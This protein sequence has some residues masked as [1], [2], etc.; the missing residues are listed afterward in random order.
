MEGSKVEDFNLTDEQLQKLS[1]RDLEAL[2]R[3]DHAAISTYGLHVLANKPVDFQ[4]SEALKNLPASAGRY[5]KDSVK[6]LVELPAVAVDAYNYVK[7]GKPVIPK[8]KEIGG[9][10]ADDIV[11]KYGSVDQFKLSLQEDPAQVLGDISTVLAPLRAL[12]GAA[13]KAATT[14]VNVADPVAWAARGAKGLGAAGKAALP[15]AWPARMYSADT[16]IAN[17][18]VVQELLK[19]GYHP[20]KP[21]DLERLANDINTTGSGIR[22]IV[23]DN[24][25]AVTSAT[26]FHDML[27]AY[28]KVNEPNIAGAAGARGF[29]HAAGEIAKHMGYD[30]GNLT[31]EAQDLRRMLGYKDP[32]LT[33]PGTVLG[34]DGKPLDPGGLMPSLNEVDPGTDLYNLWEQK[35]GGWQSVLNRK[36]DLKDLAPGRA[37]GV[38]AA[39][40][41]ATF[42]V[43]D[44]LNSELAGTKYR[45]LAEK[46]GLEVDMQEEMVKAAK[47]LATSNS[48]LAATHTIPI[49]VGG[50]IG[51]SVGGSTGGLLGALT[52][53]GLDKF[54]SP[55]KRISAAIALEK[56]YHET[57]RDYLDLPVGTWKGP[58]ANALNISE[59]ERARLKRKQFQ[60]HY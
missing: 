40:E 22:N 12:P 52:A 27:P 13:G 54:A 51:Y 1:T 59:E 8:L 38:Q 29:R 14:A 9:L 60:G 18:S 58:A 35:R 57:L 17:Q 16:G 7:E 36:G 3:D 47:R 25:K 37:A 56:P 34:V 32:P 20:G 48:P 19:R 28:N 2:M 5:I 26:V 15:R 44:T 45:T 42:N 10:V 24:N 49:G 50:S 43:A 33:E 30:P 21:V 23:K 31:A 46:Y 39:K 53:F 6:G 55:N 41:K 11:S 4:A